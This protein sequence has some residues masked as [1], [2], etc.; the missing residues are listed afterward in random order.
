MATLELPLALGMA[1][2]RPQTPVTVSGFK[3]QIDSTG[4][5]VVKSTHSLGDNGFTTRVE[6]ELGDAKQAT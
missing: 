3:P 1:D 2:L 4:W 5:L 6:M